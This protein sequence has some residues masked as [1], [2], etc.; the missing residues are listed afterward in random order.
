M[1]R[2]KKRTFLIA[3]IIIGIAFVAVVEF[4]LPRLFVVPIAPR[5]YPRLHHSRR[6]RSAR[7]TTSR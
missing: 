6:S 3:L 2:S 4:Y 7:R 1:F 5:Q